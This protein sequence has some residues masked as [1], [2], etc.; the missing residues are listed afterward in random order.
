M[1]VSLDLHMIKCFKFLTIINCSETYEYYQRLILVFVP[2]ELKFYVYYLSI[3]QSRFGEFALKISSF[4][5]IYLL[6]IIYLDVSM[7]SLL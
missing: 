2:G 4:I 5:V 6:Y 1:Q 7:D 3:T